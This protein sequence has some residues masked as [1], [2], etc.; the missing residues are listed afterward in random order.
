MAPSL[1]PAT[2]QPYSLARRAAGFPDRPLKPN[3]YQWIPRI[4]DANAI[5]SF[6]GASSRPFMP[7]AAAES[8]NRWNA[9]FMI[10]S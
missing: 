5:C 2:L 3:R 8:G 6:D 4:T 7:F 9:V 10:T 1:G